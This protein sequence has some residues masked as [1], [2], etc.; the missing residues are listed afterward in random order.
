MEKMRAFGAQYIIF[1]SL[2]LC[3]IVNNIKLRLLILA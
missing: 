2:S 1:F 3:L